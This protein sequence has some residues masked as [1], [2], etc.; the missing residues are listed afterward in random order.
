[1]ANNS[2]FEK[3]KHPKWQ[4]KRL[5]IMERAGFV[6]EWCGS[7]ENELHVHHGYY[8]R[9]DPWDYPDE[10]LYCL[11]DKC[12][13]EAQ[14]QKLTVHK[15]IARIHPKNLR[16]CYRVIARFKHNLDPGQ[17]TDNKPSINSPQPISL[18]GRKE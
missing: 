3:L 18:F 13:Q 16:E 5:R 4:E 6:C 14:T 9:L 17:I 10:T 2:Y 11:C 1:M 7:A 12:H 8:E 15:E